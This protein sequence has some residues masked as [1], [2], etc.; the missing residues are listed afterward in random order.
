[1]SVGTLALWIALSAAAAVAALPVTLTLGILLAWVRRALFFARHGGG[2][3]PRHL[4]F[5]V[6]LVRELWAQ[7]QIVG[8]SLLRRG[9]GLPTPGGEPPVVLIHGLMAN[10]TSMWA[11]QRALHAAGRNT[12]APHLG[13]A[14]RPIASYAERLAT[15]L[16]RSVGPVDVVCHS[17]GGIILR[18]CLEKH[19]ELRPRIRRVVTVASPHHGSGAA[20]WLPIPE[21]RALVPGGA[22]ITALPS[23]RALLPTARITTFASRHDC[24]VYPHTTSRVDNA[25]NHEL[26]DV[27][28][29]ELI[30][31]KRVVGRVV[32]ALTGEES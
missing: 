7:L 29:A 21:A 18:A 11:L 19:A 9:R 25:T 4:P 1:M 3:A 14:L 23:L 2:Q 5:T 12:S 32:D 30:V 17:L 27:M 8:W 28:H 22:F 24:I 20:R 31:D 16:G 13:G 26:D 10:G 6:A 15:F